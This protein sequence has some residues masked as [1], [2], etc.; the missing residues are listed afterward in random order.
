[1]AFQGSVQRALPEAILTRPKQGFEMPV[2]SWLR[3]P[4]RQRFVDLVLEGDSAV[5]GLIDRSVARRLFDEHQSGR[6]RH[7]G[8]LWSLL[9]LNAWANRYLG[10]EGRGERVVP[11]SP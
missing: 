9:V 4:L 11:L 10:G 2:N 7:G 6:S 3:G 1:M 8:V 5:D